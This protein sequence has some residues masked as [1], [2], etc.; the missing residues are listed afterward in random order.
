MPSISVVIPVLNDA[1]VL[2]RL[3]T[4]LGSSHL[5]VVVVDGGSQDN[6][7]AVAGRFGYRVFDTPPNRGLQLNTG[8]RHSAGAWLWLL[9]ADSTVSPAIVAAVAEIANGPAGWGR[10]DV[11]FAAASAMLKV[12]AQGM[13]HRSWLTGICTG[14]QGMFVHRSLLEAIGGVPEQP[15]MEDVELSKRLRRIGKPVRRRELLTTSTRRWQRHGVIRTMA[16]MWWLRLRY[17]FGADPEVLVRD[18]YD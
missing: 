11:E 9:H 8:V 16:R 17:F 5:E 1:A 7:V 14:D 4:D 6:S 13:N 3:L 12:I 10:F 2:E 15:L 18:Y